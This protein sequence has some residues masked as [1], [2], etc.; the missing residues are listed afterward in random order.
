MPWALPSHPSEACQSLLPMWSSSR[1]PT[2]SPLPIKPFITSASFEWPSHFL[3]VLL[4]LV[5][6]WSPVFSQLHALDSEI[7]ESGD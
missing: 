3:F 7:L 5:L 2:L 4:S 1:F 6:S